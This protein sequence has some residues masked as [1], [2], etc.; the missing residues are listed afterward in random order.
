MSQFDRFT[1]SARRVVQ[2]AF[3]E[4]KRSTH[5]FVGTEHLLFGILCDTDG[6]GC[7]LLLVLDVKPEAMLQAVEKSLRQNEDG[8]AMERFPLSP[9]SRRVFKAADEEAASKMIGPQHLLVGLLCEPDCVAAE[10]L[11]AH[12]IT[13]DKARTAMA[14]LPPDVAHEAK[15]QASGS[16]NTLGPNPTVDELEGW[17]TPPGNDQR[18][19]TVKPPLLE[20]GHVER[21]LR[22]TQLVL[23]SLLGYAFGFWLD[24]LGMGVAFAMVGF[25][26]A[27]MRNSAVG[28]FVGVACAALFSVAYHRNDA[29]WQCALHVAIGFFA[30]TFLGDFWRFRRASPTA[31]AKER[32]QP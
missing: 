16:T 25:V 12:G 21:Q 6:P 23:G 20:A 9:A 1:A 5:D 27:L 28:A 8:L 3:R 24:G 4:A 13:L 15:I 10:I 32:G 2:R 26:T 11:G 18:E 31:D 7:A 29:I 22:W 19:A 14:H 30:G 17:I